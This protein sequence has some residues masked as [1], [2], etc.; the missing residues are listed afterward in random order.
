MR[1][2][3]PMAAELEQILRDLTEQHERLR[4]TSQRRRAAIRAAD[5]G[6]MAEC[7]TA[8]AA[9]AQRIAEIETRREGLVQRA[10]ERF[11][12]PADAGADW[13]PTISWI[14][15]RLDEPDSS[16]LAALAGAL[17][18][19][20]EGLRAERL[21]VRDAADALA[22]HMR[23]LIRAVESRLNHSGAYGRRGVVGAGPAVFSALDLTT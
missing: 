16:R 23:G 8:E 10:I 17:R 11:G 14:A 19:L 21:A 3:D 6:A 18:E 7:L 13:R 9:L 20:I 4:A 1:K 5:P 15:A 2:P 12:R 22:S